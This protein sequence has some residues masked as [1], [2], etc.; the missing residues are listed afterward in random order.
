MIRRFF[1]GLAFAVAAGLVGAALLHL[2]IVLALPHFSEND[3]Y[4]RVLK[5]G[6]TQRF[7][8][9]TETAD[10]AG[11]SKVDPFVETAVC[12]FD[13]SEGPVRLTAENTGLP[14]WSLGIY[15]GASNEVFS[16]NDRTSPGGMLDVVIATPTQMTMLR[17]SL[18][19]GISQ[20]I[21]VESQS[22]EGYAVLRAL[23]PQASFSE[24]ATQ[25]LK[26][27]DCGA[28]QWRGRSRF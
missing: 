27:A 23:T 4:T 5:E 24:A 28:F 22:G 17:K 6:E 12:G 2:I 8:R 26:D 18:P 25:F 11:L 13:V 3:A 10:R 15:D 14:F 20:S 9:L 21:L 16:I 1:T 7:Y 19:T